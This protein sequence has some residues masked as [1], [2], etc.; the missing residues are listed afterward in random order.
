VTTPPNKRQGAKRALYYQ[1]ALI[2]RLLVRI[3]LRQR[4]V[5]E[6]QLGRNLYQ[7]E[8]QN[9]NLTFQGADLKVSHRKGKINGIEINLSQ[10][11]PELIPQL[12]TF[13]QDHRPKSSRG[14]STSTYSYH[15]GAIRSLNSQ[16]AISSKPSCMRIRASAFTLT[17]SAP[18]GPLNTSPQP[19]ISLRLLTCSMTASIRS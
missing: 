15:N 4:N 6:M 11:F 8:R 5:R 10:D 9:W 2:L 14:R 7:D 13:L 16:C 3:P 12:E 17:W 19:A 1:R 18:S